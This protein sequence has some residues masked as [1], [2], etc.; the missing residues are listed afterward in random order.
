MRAVGVADG[1]G[2]ARVRGAGGQLHKIEPSVDRDGWAEKE[3][4][5]IDKMPAEVT[6]EAAGRASLQ[7]FG[8]VEVQAGVYAPDLTKGAVG[9][10]LAEGAEIGVPAAVLETPRT[11]PFAPCGAVEF[12]GRFG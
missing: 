12:S 7:R 6:Q 5:L 9:N 10:D 11:T 3:E 1:D 8:F 4:R 2:E